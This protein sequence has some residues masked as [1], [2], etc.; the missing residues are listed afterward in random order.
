MSENFRSFE[1]WEI[2]ADATVR[3][4]PPTTISAEHKAVF[5]AMLH[6][7][8]QVG[9]SGDADLI[10]YLGV[11]MGTSSTKVVA[12]LPFEPGQP[13]MPIPAPQHCRSDDH[14]A[15][16]QTVLWMRMRMRNST[17]SA[18]PSSDARPLHNLKQAAVGASFSSRTPLHSVR[19]TQ[20]TA[21]YL[22]YVIRHA[23]GWLLSNRSSWFRRRNPGWIVQVGLPAKSCDESYLAIAYRRMALTGMHLSRSPNE[24]TFSDAAEMLSRDDVVRAS[25]S[26]EKSLEQGVAVF[27]ELAAA[28]TSFSKSNER[29]N[30]LYLIVDVGAMTMDV[31]AFYLG[32]KQGGDTYSIFAADVR[33]LGVEARYWFMQNGRSDD[34]FRT[35]IQLLPAR[36]GDKDEARE[37]ESTRVPPWQRPSVL[38]CWWRSE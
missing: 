30:G 2:P 26:N 35:Q 38:F 6:A 22:G 18:S 11:D 14:P 16:W 10:V 17:F 28:T 5:N 9:P 12:R 36:S 8:D 7:A 1:F 33:P 19:Q 31:C 27:P 23:K 32:R 4:S 24:I 29:A 13:C 3:E 15:L 20:A 21:A 34:A 37:S 25:T